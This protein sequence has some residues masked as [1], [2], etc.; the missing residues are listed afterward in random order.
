[1]SRHA[2]PAAATSP[3]F[4]RNLGDAMLAG[5]ELE[6]I[7]RLFREARDRA[8]RPDDLAL[9]IRHE[10]EGRLHCEVKVYFPPAAAGVARAVDALACRR[11]AVDGL[12]LLAGAEAAWRLLFPETSG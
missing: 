6:R 2:Q 10:A 12:G 3:W 11:P 9:F 1:M 5:A 7:E 8:G 4:C